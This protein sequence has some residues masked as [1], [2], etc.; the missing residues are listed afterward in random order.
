MKTPE[1][2]ATELI[3]RIVMRG[4][5]EFMGTHEHDRDDLWAAIATAAIE[6]DRAQHNLLEAVANA[7][8][9]RGLPEHAAYVAEWGDPDEI[10][11][12]F[13]GPMLDQIADVRL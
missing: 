7:L 12:E 11:A 9:D 4:T 3:D 1:Q 10:W 8:R 6:A 13:I 5:I 2:I